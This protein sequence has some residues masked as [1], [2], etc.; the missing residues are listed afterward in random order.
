[1]R[2]ALAAALFAL[3][4]VIAFA[5]ARDPVLFQA[6][7]N[8]GPPQLTSAGDVSVAFFSG[9][10]SEDLSLR[11]SDGR[12]LS[13]GP[14]ISIDAP[15]TSDFISSRAAAVVGT[16]VHVFWSD[17][18]HYQVPLW[19]MVA[20]TPFLR[21]LDTTTGVLGP[22][23]ALPI[24]TLPEHTSALDRDFA[25]TLH[26]GAVHLHA[27]TFERRLDPTTGSIDNVIVLDSS[28]DGGATWLPRLELTPPGSVS[29][30]SVRVLTQGPNVHVLYEDE[31][32]FGKS[33]LFHQRSSD[34]GLT[35]DFPAPLAI[36]ESYEVNGFDVELD[37]AHL[38]LAIERFASDFGYSY[39][40]L[41]TSPDRGTSFHPPSTISSPA[42]FVDQGF[43]ARIAISPGTSELVAI[44]TVSDLLFQTHVVAMHSPDGGL[45]WSPGVVLDTGPLSRVD[46]TAAGPGR[47]RVVATWQAGVGTTGQLEAQVSLDRGKVFGPTLPL[48]PNL[49]AGRFLAWNDLYQ[50]LLVSFADW[51]SPK[52]TW[53]GGLRPQ[54]I[55]V[56]G[57]AGGST[58]L[59]VDFEG[60]DGGADLAWVLFSDSDAGLALPGDRDLGLGVSALLVD[61]L[62]LA[63]S[64]LFAA[65]LTPLG[66]GST[67]SL[68]VPA[69]GIPPGLTLFA[70]G[71]GID[72]QSATVVD[73]SDAVRLDT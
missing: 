1:M 11:L 27:A 8:G 19:P 12:G 55:G 45:S 22:E 59:T 2:L 41:V 17:D 66:G 6:S 57:V 56:S 50:N 29:F 34:G 44:G 68:P 70:V 3:H 63:A 60:F 58:A 38:A 28:H 46:V 25:A 69:P 35:L 48:A 5:D 4:P 71:V 53:I 52:A 65:P 73:I 40:S 20:S 24:S 18:R 23:L 30:G 64:G 54:A 31:V 42:V 15:G 10:L 39:T 7:S 33:E 61:S 62:G 13:F 47:D 51:S 21:V 67:G 26:A 49:V 9:P 43:E 32:S 72:L 36:P 16:E 14:T 37:G